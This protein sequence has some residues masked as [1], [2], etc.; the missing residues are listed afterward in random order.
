MFKPKIWLRLGLWPWQVQ[1]RHCLSQ[2]SQQRLKSTAKKQPG[3]RVLPDPFSR[4]AAAEAREEKGA[5]VVRAAKL[6]QAG[7]LLRPRLLHNSNRNPKPSNEE[8]S[9]V[10]AER[11]ASAASDPAASAPRPAGG[12]Q[13]KEKEKKKKGSEVSTRATSSDSP[14]ARIRR[15]RGKK[16]LK[17]TR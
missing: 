8:A 4:R 9:E 15:E 5:K 16:N 7:L 3:S 14:R 2:S 6:A 1:R 17:T 10:R 13:E 12:N 11:A